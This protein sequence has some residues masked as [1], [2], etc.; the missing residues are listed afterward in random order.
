MSITLHHNNPTQS[1]QTSPIRLVV[2]DMDGTLLDENGSLP[3]HFWSI[4]QRLN[5]RGITFVA[6]SGRQYPTLTQIFDGRTDG[7]SFIAENG[8]Y[9]VQDNVEVTASPVDRDYAKRFVSCVRQ[10]VAAGNDIGTVWC[11][12][13][14]AY[15]E[16]ADAAFLAEAGR[17]YAHLETVERFEDVAEDALKFAVWVAGDPESAELDG[18]R[19]GCAPGRAVLSAAHWFDIMQPEINKGTALRGLQRQLGITAEETVVF[20]DYLND[21][22]MLDEASHSYAMANAHPEVLKR[23]RYIAP[24]NSEHGVL[25]VVARLIGEAA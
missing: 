4:L 16:R 25:Q 9:V 24:P 2:S 12:R 19:A 17:Y 21:L 7:M 18:L 6:A 10:Q 5:D 15:V 11:G 20:G 22:E 14:S 23:A 8:T 13:S 1:L 3:A